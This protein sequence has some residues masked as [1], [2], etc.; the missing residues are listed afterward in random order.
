MP[1]VA[2]AHPAH[3]EPGAAAAPWRQRIERVLRARR[4]E[5]TRGGRWT[6][7]SRHARMGSIMTRGQR[8]ADGLGKG[9]LVIA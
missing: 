3:R 6:L 9:A 4:V 2:A 8:R 5:S 1:G 7:I